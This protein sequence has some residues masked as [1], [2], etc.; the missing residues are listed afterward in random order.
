[1]RISVPANRSVTLSPPVLFGVSVLSGSLLS[2]SIV[3]ITSLS[4]EFQHSPSVV[5]FAG[6][7]A[8]ILVCLLVAVCQSET[9]ESRQKYHA[10]A[11]ECHGCCSDSENK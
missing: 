11:P 3:L 5:F 9:A 4:P 2:G 8:S 6:V 7:S 1:M 10:F